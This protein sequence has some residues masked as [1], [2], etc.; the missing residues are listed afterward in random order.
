M[1]NTSLQTDAQLA[2]VLDHAPV[3]VYVSAIEDHK[4]LYANRLVQDFLIKEVEGQKYCFH[5]AGFD[6]E[7]SFCHK[8][9]MNRS[10][11]LVREYRHPSDGHVYELSGRIIDWNG[12]P[13]H[14]EYI[15]DITEKKRTEEE[16]KA[17][18][19]EL[20][21]ILSSV[22]GGLCVYRYDGKEILPIFHNPSFYSI[23]GYSSEHVKSVEQQTSYLNVHPDDL[24]ELQ[25]KIREVLISNGNIEHTYRLW[26]DEKK[27]YR[28]IHLEGRVKPQADGI[29]LLYGEYTDVSDQKELEQTLTE[30]N[31]K[32]S[33]IVNAIPGGVAIY[34][35]SDIFETVYFSDGVAE[36]AGYTAEEYRE[37]AKGDAAMLTYREDVDMVVSNL[38]NALENHTTADFEFRNQH[39]DGHIVWVNAHAR[40]V[41]EEDGY[42]LLQCVFHNISELK[43]AQSE[44]RH[45]MNSVPGGIA[46]YR[47]EAEKA[48]TAFCSD[49]VLELFG[50][51]RTELTDVLGRDILDR[52]HEPDRDRVKLALKA[53]LKSGEIMD[54]YYRVR[55]KNGNLIWIHA[56]GRRMGPQTENAQFYVVYTGVSAETRL[57]QNLTDENDGAIYVIDKES[58]ELLYV[59]ESEKY[60]AH[61]E[62]CLGRKC[63]EALYGKSEP[64]SF[65]TLKSGEPDGK[66]QEMRV[67]GLDRSFATSFQEID[68]NGVPAYVKYIKDTTEEIRLRSERDR[69]N[70]YFQ[71]MVQN[72]PGGVMVITLSKDA[73][74]VPEYI[75]QGFAEM[76]GMSLEEA[77]DLYGEDARDG[78]H[79]EDWSGVSEQMDRCIYGNQDHF[80]MEYRLKKGDGS[81]VWVR[82]NFSV[83]QGEHG[84]RRMYVIY[85]DMT[86]EIEEKEQVRR[87][88]KEM[89]YL[90]YQKP[91]PNALVVGHCNITQ[92]RILEIIDHTDSD[93]LETFSSVREDFFTGLSGLIVEEEERQLFLN[94][95]LSKPALKAFYRNETEQ[96]Q[97]CFVH[98][99]K[100]RVGRY[101]KVTMA[102]IETP[103]SGD[104]TGIL[105]ITDITE[106]VVSDK[107]LHQLSVSGYD[108]VASLDLFQDVF[109]VLS[110]NRDAT[111]IPPMNGSNTEWQEKMREQNIVPR[112]REI[113]RQSL[114]TENIISRL[115]EKGAY[116]F[117]FSVVDEN[118]EV[119]IKNM[120]VSEIDLRLGRVCLSRMD[121]TESMREQQ[122]MLNMLAYT[123]D[124]AGFVNLQTGQFTMYTRKIVLENLAPYI[125]EDYRK[126]LPKL[127]GN[128]EG[129]GCCKEEI[130]EKFDLEH[131]L[132]QLEEKPS[133]YDFVVPYNGEGELRYKQVNVLWGDLNH[134]TVCLVRMDVT[135]V[136]ANERKAKRA[137][138]EALETAKEANSAKSDFLSTM[139]HDIRTPLNA[140]MGMTE[141]AVAHA[142]DKERV[143][144]CL[145]KISTSSRHLLSLVND[146][147]DV[148][149]LER[150]G[151][152][153]NRLLISLPDLLEQLSAIMTPQAENAGVELAFHT[154]EITHKYFYGDT[155]RINQIFINILGNAVKFTPGGGEVLF[156]TEEIPARREGMIRYRFTVKD[157]GIGMSREFLEHMYEPFTRSRNAD[158]IE[159]TGLGLNIVKGLVDLL[160]GSIDVSSSVGVGTTFVIELEEEPASVENDAWQGKKDNPAKKEILKNRRVLVAEDNAIN[161]EIT[162]GL[163]ELFGMESVVRTDGAQTVREFQNTPPGTYDAI[164]MDIRM[165]VMNGFEATKAI[166]HMDRRDA[167]EIPIIAMTA[168]AFVE[169]IRASLDAGMTSHVSKPIDVEMLRMTLADALEQREE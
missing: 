94:T 162:C 89:I 110:V 47:I 83:V 148:N 155:L 130:E 24:G 20:Q 118:G 55:Q 66:E 75:S 53:A 98:F 50:Y 73:P 149:K 154:G 95:Y 77:W 150:S 85:H 156:L 23:M 16:I 27:E 128:Y 3:A 21:Q 132:K 100:E 119:R 70:Q 38:R 105:T 93:L 104:I 87:Q 67:D 46:S 29:K 101:V 135:D 36:L 1:Q 147:L 15:I 160:D 57:F 120:T 113:Y 2:A 88:Y 161:A 106:R 65:C 58:Y 84:K 111:N 51:D 63:Y 76:T 169:D 74:P 35:V 45:L 143:M 146:I 91:G 134:Q 54:I 68:W 11:Y 18:R 61:H 145:K 71:T 5:V 72:L 115:Q 144:D 64:C 39:R 122:G 164:L 8:K 59:N 22:P 96:I 99:P 62:N 137:L 33:G 37:L 9:Q 31:D 123:F 139:S 166:R 109:Q 107:V 129:T 25:A 69:L 138:E 4:L 60:Y 48:I 133:G 34:K 125:V 80:S 158:Q 165:P 117:A 112:D 49:G 141:L 151:I 159:G 17:R 152:K 26:N 30:T 153:L 163:L 92:N 43:E 52:I 19:E 7:C 124:I 127:S 108:F 40:Q 103:D 126:A 79:L 32:M 12:Q 97:E 167:S 42:P 86:R 142:D 6:R 102:M 56:N 116:S 44:M 81:W 28:W 131:I 114:T 82:P 14:I 157:T 168:N 10:D 13:A 121:I 90:H 78:V 140:I 41:G 136:L